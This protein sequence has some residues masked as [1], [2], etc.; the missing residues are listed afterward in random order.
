MCAF[1]SE[2]FPFPLQQREVAKEGQLSIQRQRPN[3]LVSATRWG[4]NKEGA[5]TLPLSPPLLL[6]PLQASCCQKALELLLIPIRWESLEA[7]L[8][9]VEGCLSHH[10]H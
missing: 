7:R 10:R 4:G 1:E 5:G 8:V 3:N 6:A 2:L 9:F